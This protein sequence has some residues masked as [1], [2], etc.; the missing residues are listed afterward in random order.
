MKRKLFFAASRTLLVVLLL[1]LLIFT[2]PERLPLPAL[3]LP[4]LLV[5][6]IVYELIHLVLSKLT[7]ESS[8]LRRRSFVA[9]ISSLP[10]VVLL[11]SSAGQVGRYD[12]LLF[13]VLGLL[14]AF[15]F[16]RYHFSK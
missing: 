10:V 14:L 12:L 3:L 8:T 15:Y 13:L 7:V 1:C 9:I 4:F 2:N 16:S 11:L 5:Y 6:L